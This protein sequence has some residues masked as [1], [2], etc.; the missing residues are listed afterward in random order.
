M[1]LKLLQET[2]GGLVKQ[3]REL[4][5]AAAAEKRALTADEQNKLA[6]IEGEI[7]GLTVTIDAEMRQ[8]ARESTIAPNLSKDEQRTVDRFSL[9]KL[10]RHIDRAF[11]GSP[12]ALDGAEAEMVQEGERE[13][14]G[15]GLNISGIALPSLLI[16]P[17]REQRATLSVTGGT[18]DQYGGALVATEKRGLIGDF[19]NSSVIEQAGALV[20]TGLVNNLDIPRYVAGTAPVKK[21]ENEAAG[22]V[23]GTFTDLNLTPKRLPGYAEISDQLLMQS[24]ANVELFVGGEIQKSMN[25]VKE[26]AFFHGTG[27]SEPTGI[28]A[29]NGIGSV[30]GGT[31]GAAPDWADI[32]DLET[33]VAVD[34]ALDG[35]VR[36]FTNAKVRG[37]L[38]KTLNTSSTD[39]V[40][41]WDV[42]TPD[43][44][45]NGYAA[46]ITNAIRSDLTKGNQS[47]SSAIF[48]GNAGDFVIGYWG[49]IMLEMVRDS[50][51]AKA[52]KRTLVASTYYD[53]GVR[54]AQSFSAMLDALTA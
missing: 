7:D 17:V 38:K 50:T 21:T 26:R 18:T 39:S 36:Y 15:S 4:L 9:G 35:A 19:Y 42:R 3:A 8:I 54:R 29:T 20:F 1:K 27:T 45:L 44:P 48:F 33:E 12:V 52:G 22:D 16:K 31:N 49:G 30:V 25:A 6:N 2:R 10:V 46:S 14:R 34:N 51:D 13:A 28:A 47:L 11:R 43:A 32:V 5:D 23:A 40:K 41:V 37:K 53:A 24:D